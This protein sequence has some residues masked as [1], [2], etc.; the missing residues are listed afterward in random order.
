VHWLKDRSSRVR[1]VAIQIAEEQCMIG[2]VGDLAGLVLIDPHTRAKA[3]QAL[4]HFQREEAL[5]LAPDD[6]KAKPVE[7]LIRSAKQEALHA[8][9][10]TLLRDESP[11]VREVA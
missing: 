5:R 2:A 9:L 11:G 10:T 1:E 4:L 6:P 7:T 8:S 3:A